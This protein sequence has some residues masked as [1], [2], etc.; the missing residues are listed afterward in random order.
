VERII[1]TW[2]FIPKD[3]ASETIY[4]GDAETSETIELNF[5]ITEHEAKGPGYHIL[6]LIE[7]NEL[8]VEFESSDLWTPNSGLYKTMSKYISNVFKN[9]I[10]P[11]HLYEGYAL[12][13]DEPD[14]NASNFKIIESYEGVFTNE[15]QEYNGKI[16]LRY[17]L[18][19]DG[20][21]YDET[22]CIGSI[23]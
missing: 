21:I 2:G 22:I 12:V 4:C 13:Q 18:E 3:N 10:T 6:K 1:I 16:F 7:D 20:E 14:E 17:Y 19:E 9:T 15:A 5:E 8:Y 23:N 11:R